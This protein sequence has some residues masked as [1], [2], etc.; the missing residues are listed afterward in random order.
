MHCFQSCSLCLQRFCV[1][2]FAGNALFD[3]SCQTKILPI[4]G[5]PIL[6]SP[7]FV[8][9]TGWR[10]LA[11]HPAEAWTRRRWL[12]GHWHWDRL[13][14]TERGAGHHQ[15]IL[16]GRRLQCPPVQVDGE[17]GAAVAAERQD[18]LPVEGAVLHPHHRL[19]AVLQ[20][21]VVQSHGDGGVHLQGKLVLGQSRA[22]K[23]LVIRWFL[24]STLSGELV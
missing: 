14:E 15:P 24:F 12:H 23:K 9:S 17:K 4:D 2:F 16:R 21:G 11:E 18:I 13:W 3:C 22:S 20:K 5:I 8:F 19:L 7:L 6:K 1:Q 10:W